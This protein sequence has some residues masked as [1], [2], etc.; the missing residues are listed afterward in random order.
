M[1]VYDSARNSQ[2]KS[3]NR[4]FFEPFST[5][6]AKKYN[7]RRSL[8]TRQGENA[9]HNKSTHMS[10][11]RRSNNSSCTGGATTP[12]N[13][14]N[15]RASLRTPMI[16]YAKVDLADERILRSLGDAIRKPTP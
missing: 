15:L 5:L 6:D 2:D 7:V 3:S 13:G 9:R 4:A 16:I 1:R 12:E 11:V 14:R 8:V 10:S